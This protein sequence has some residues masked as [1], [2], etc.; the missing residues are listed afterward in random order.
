MSK[1]KLNV[2]TFALISVLS[3]CGI[4]T[5]QHHQQTNLIS[6]LP[7]LAARTDPNLVNPWGIASA[8]PSGPWWV[9]DNGKGISVLY[10]GTG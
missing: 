5:A 7:G 8:S 9:N 3:L 6:D 10:D 1:G 4:A 2:V